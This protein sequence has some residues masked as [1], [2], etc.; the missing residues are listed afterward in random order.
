MMLA[1]PSASVGAPP[2]RDTIDSS[3]TAAAVEASMSGVRLTPVS[4]SE[5][6]NATAPSMV[7]PVAATDEFIAK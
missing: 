6:T 4:P 7:P 2:V 5:F 1:R 3:P